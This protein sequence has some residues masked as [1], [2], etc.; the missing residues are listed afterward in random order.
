VAVALVTC[1]QASAPT[2]CLAE[3]GISLLYLGM[4]VN[5]SEGERAPEPRICS[6]YIHSIYIT[7]FGPSHFVH[8]RKIVLMMQLQFVVPSIDSSFRSREVCPERHVIG[9]NP[10][11]LNVRQA[12]DVAAEDT[13]E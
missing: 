12:V 7:E 5:V 6:I 9:L 2:G 10:V 8:F 13:C 1:L 4:Y 11:R 3:E